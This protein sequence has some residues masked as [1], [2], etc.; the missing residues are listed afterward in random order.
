MEVELTGRQITITDGLRAQA[1]AGISRIDRLIG[2][3]TAHVIL[4]AEKYRQIAEVTITTRLLTLVATCEATD[5]V[6][7]LHDTL[8]KIEQQA[9]RHNQKKTTIRRHPK[10][11]LKTV[12]RA[13]ANLEI[14]PEPS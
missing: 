14:S 1:E 13:Q 9:I 3:G 5:M 7:A 4:T 11:D 2:S 6:T 10:S 8:A 12:A